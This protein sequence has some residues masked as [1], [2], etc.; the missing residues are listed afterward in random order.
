M[1]AHDLIYVQLQLSL[2]RN[3]QVSQYLEREL[4]CGQTLPYRTKVFIGINI[5]EIH[6][7]QNRARFKPTKS[8]TYQVP[9]A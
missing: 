1:N 2:C 8:I 4:S 9:V 3:E 7:C 6:D 5:R